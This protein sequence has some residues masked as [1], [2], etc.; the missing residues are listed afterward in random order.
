MEPFQGRSFYKVQHAPTLARARESISNSLRSPC[1]WWENGF[2]FAFTAHS[3]RE[4]CHVKVL[5]VLAVAFPWIPQTF[6][7]RMEL[8]AGCSTG[9]C[10]ASAWS[11]R[12]QG[13]RSRGKCVGSTIFWSIEDIVSTAIASCIGATKCI[14]GVGKTGSYPSLRRWMFCILCTSSVPWRVEFVV[15]YKMHPGI[16]LRRLRSHPRRSC[17]RHV[18]RAD[19]MESMS[20]CTVFPSRDPCPTFLGG[21]EGC[22][23][24]PLPLRPPTLVWNPTVAPPPSRDPNRHVGP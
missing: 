7:S 9:R 17:A 12:S 10:G 5:L 22:H 13:P 6:S 8:Y 4:S 14:L 19:S 21:D 23:T 2:A 1:R 18:Y 11:T 3:H 24:R 15:L 16:L 20:H